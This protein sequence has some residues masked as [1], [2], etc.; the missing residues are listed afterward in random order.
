[1]QTVGSSKGLAALVAP[2][3]VGPLV[4][5]MGSSNEDERL[6]AAR[7]AAILAQST[8]T[9]EALTSGKGCLCIHRIAGCLHAAQCSQAPPLP[10]AEP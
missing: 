6:H 1:V 7:L 9:H 5:M 3:A 2:L 10:V 4:T 8:P